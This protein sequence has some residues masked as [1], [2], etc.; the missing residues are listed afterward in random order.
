MPYSYATYTGNG[1]TT[2]FA[3]PFGYI[4][5]EHVLA[6][7]AT[8]SATF[9]WV[10]DSL[11]QMTTAPANGAAVRVYRLTPLTAPLV[12][13]ADG[14][15]LVAADLDTNAKQSIY[16]QQELDD[17]LAG[18]ALG[19]IPNGDKGDIT[20]SVGGTVWTVD[21]DLASRLSFTQ[22]G[23]GTVART[24]DNKLKDVVSVKDFGAVGNGVTND[25]VAIQAAVNS[26]AKAVY[27]PAGTYVTGSSNTQIALV[28]NQT[29]FGDKGQS[30]IK[31]HPGFTMDASSEVSYRFLLY[32]DNKN[33]ITVRGLSFL[34]NTVN[35]IQ[36]KLAFKNC[37]DLAVE[38]CYFQENGT[39]DLLF[40]NCSRFS[41]NNCEFECGVSGVHTGVAMRI[42]NK[43]QDFRISNSI[44]RGS[45]VTKLQAGG[46][47]QPAGDKWGSSLLVIDNGPTNHLNS[48]G[49]KGGKGRFN[50]LGAG[51]N[52]TV[53]IPGI[54]ATDWEAFVEQPFEV[55]SLSST[56][57]RKAV[58]TITTDTITFSSLPSG[59]ALE[60]EYQYVYWGSTPRD[61]IITG[62]FFS[63]G[64][65]S[66][67][68]IINGIRVTTSGCYFEHTGDVSWDPEGTVDCSCFGSTFYDCATPALVIG[69][70]TVFAGNSINKA[71]AAIS[72][73]CKAGAAYQALGQ[74][75]TDFANEPHEAYSVFVDAPTG[76]FQ[77]VYDIGVYGFQ[78]THVFINEWVRIYHTGQWYEYKVN[79][80][81]SNGSISI[82]NSKVRLRYAEETLLGAP[83]PI[84]AGSYA[85]GQW[86]KSPYAIAMYGL[87]GDS[88]IS[89]NTIQNVTAAIY[90]D[91]P[92]RLSLVGN[93]VSNTSRAIEIT[94]AVDLNISGGIYA[95]RIYVKDSA[96][97][98]MSGVSLS[99][100]SQRGLILDNVKFFDVGNVTQRD[101]DILGNTGTPA[102]VYGNCSYGA[103]H[104]I[105]L[106]LQNGNGSN[107]QPTI[108]EGT[109]N[110]GT[111]SINTATKNNTYVDIYA[112]RSFKNGLLLLDLVTA[113]A[114]ADTTP[115]VS[116]GRI[117]KTANA[118]A[119]TITTFDD[120]FVGKQFTLRAGDANTTIQNSASLVLKGGV[121]KS[122]ATG[123]T[124]S[125]LMV[126]SG[127][128]SEI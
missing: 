34:L 125:F 21:S 70:G 23:A 22:T 121:N 57:Q 83:V 81:L 87:Q 122:L 96:G 19:A 79:S 43:S 20:T 25:T 24:V 45:L 56:A 48:N 46:G 76:S 97:L 68:S 91:Y 102:I 30:F 99:R 35:S 31:A 88:V 124:I 29:L 73:D 42:C 95:G 105:T 72:V 58:A 50:T 60:Y 109:Y 108:V 37:S 82:D 12:D 71:I 92:I 49:F 13:F 4:R 47:N 2:Q 94:K 38:D 67:I 90:G 120:G 103:I 7:V 63:G 111:N 85:S 33:K 52:Q 44:F 36:S 15:T 51:A 53:T 93:T 110:N 80:K 18:V 107:G 59:L 126:D 74:Q 84:P 8:V 17:A 61:G 89:G 14:A 10:N 100:S 3:V 11:I 65:W 6:T 98:Q 1:S 41:I 106:S 115:S 9:T 32:G 78:F 116:L 118:G 16:T 101:G 117:F 55:T 64:T 114:N 5:R 86:K 123:E 112:I 28:S 40:N 127:V 66:H 77:Y 62:C 104:D 27:F 113:F 39:W 119:T 54:N 128:W 75:G 26:G 69:R